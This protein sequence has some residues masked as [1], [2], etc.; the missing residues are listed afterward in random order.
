MILLRK[1]VPT[2]LCVSWG[3][4]GRNS[5]NLDEFELATEHTVLIQFRAAVMLFLINSNKCLIKVDGYSA[6][7][8]QLFLT[9][10]LS[11]GEYTAAEIQHTFAIRATECEIFQDS[12]PAIS[13]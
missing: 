10:V 11:E 5:A 3:V 2:T 6:W 12:L 7:M 13:L 9:A 1:H 8:Y 4:L